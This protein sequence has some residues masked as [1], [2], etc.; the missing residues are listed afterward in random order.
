M[1]TLRLPSLAFT[2]LLAFLSLAIPSL[3][4]NTPPRAPYTLHKQVREVLTD[5]TVTDANGNPVTGLPQSAFH[6]YDDGHPQTITSFIAHAGQDRAV[7]PASTHPGTYSNRYL[8]HPPAVYDVILIDTTAA[9]LIDQMVLT[10][11]LVR[12]VRHIPPGDPLAVYAHTGPRVVLVQNFTTNRP[13]LIAAIRHVIPRIPD[14][15]YQQY[16]DAT[17]INQIAGDLSQYPGRKNLLWFTSNFN[18]HLFPGSASRRD[19]EYMHP[20][21]DTLQQERIALYPIALRG[22]TVARGGIH[23][24]PSAGH[25]PISHGTGGGSFKETPQ[26]SYWSHGVTFQDLPAE[27]ILMEGA[28]AATGGHA[29]YNTNGLAQAARQVIHRSADFYTISYSPNDIHHNNHWHQVRVTVAGNYHLNYR[30]GYYDD[31]SGTP[32]PPKPYT[33]ASKNTI[34]T[35]NA[36]SDP[37]IFQAH[38]RPASKAQISA[39]H[40]KI[41]RREHAYAIRYLLPAAAFS[42]SGAG[43]AKVTVGTAAVVVDDGGVVVGKR[44]QLLQLKLNASQLHAHPHASFAVTQTIAAPK[45][46]NHLYLAVWNTSTGRLGTLQIPLTVQKH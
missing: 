4:Q 5:V 17:E 3:A 38:L 44:L 30:R 26:Q 23:P 36:H 41:P 19:Y 33:L 11:Q 37:I 43:H 29:Y 1:L 31:E 25:S 40:P 9:N 39:A 8:N 2:V 10:Q 45:G 18:L 34:Q 21:Y 27:H 24:M 28:A 7:L 46:H 35:P 12:L 22:L 16:S 14:A 6:I 32:P 42:P 13:K 15:D 20:L